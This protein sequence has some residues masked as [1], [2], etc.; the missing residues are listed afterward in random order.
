MATLRVDTPTNH[1]QRRHAHPTVHTLQGDAPGT[2]LS[3]VHSRP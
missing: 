3:S 2:N 1:P